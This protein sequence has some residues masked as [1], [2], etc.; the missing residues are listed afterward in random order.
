MEQIQRKSRKA[1]RSIDERRTIIE[2]KIAYHE[3]HA[4]QLRKSLA[5]LDAP[6]QP[7]KSK[8]S[9]N[10][11]LAKIKDMGITAEELEKIISERKA[12]TI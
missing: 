11:A 5:D 2:Q 4:N 7:R 12:A 9:Y 3:I 6:K 8:G 10:K 1:N